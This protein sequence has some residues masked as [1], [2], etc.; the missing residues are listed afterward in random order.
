MYH[1]HSLGDTIRLSGCK[2]CIS[3]AAPPAPSAAPTPSPVWEDMAGPSPSPGT[4][5]QDP[6]PARGLRDRTPAHSMGHIPIPAPED[7]MWGHQCCGPWQWVH[8]VTH[9]LP[10]RPAFPAGK[11]SHG[12]SLAVPLAGNPRQRH[13]GVR[14]CQPRARRARGCCHSP[15]GGPRAGARGSGSGAGNAG[16]RFPSRW[17]GHEG[18]QT[19]IKARW[20]HPE[21]LLTSGPAGGRLS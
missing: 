15:G 6:H 8:P 5:E 7:E 21:F 4:G 1:P 2:C 18:E 9:S 10:S 12:R 13:C 16:R 19:V 20:C 14:L 11:L 17:V 3:P